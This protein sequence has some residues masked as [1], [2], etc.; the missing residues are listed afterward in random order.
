M[1]NNRLNKISQKI[2]EGYKDL[3]MLKLLRLNQMLSNK[4][5]GHSKV[6]F[7]RHKP[8]LYVVVFDPDEAV[9]YGYSD[10]FNP[11]RIEDRKK[12][13]KIKHEFDLKKEREVYDYLEEV[14]KN[15]EAIKN[16]L[17]FDFGGFFKKIPPNI[18][19]GSLP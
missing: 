6:G 18:M 8:K 12:R 10:L 5:E 3:C 14:E 2:N 13:N 7:I 16:P 9:G 19:Y 15:I 11:N 17:K 1:S 4:L